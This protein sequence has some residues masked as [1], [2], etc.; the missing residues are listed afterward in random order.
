MVAFLG[1]LPLASMITGKVTES[2]GAMVKGKN[3]VP[4]PKSPSPD[5]VMPPVGMTRLAVPVLWI[6]K[7]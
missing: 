4:M 3:T 6:L 5:F 2:P 7:V 1:P